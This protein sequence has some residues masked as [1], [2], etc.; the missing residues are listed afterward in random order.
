VNRALSLLY[1]WVLP[2]VGGL[3]Y[4][5]AL[6]PYNHSE[7]GW[8]ALVPLLFALE[9][10]RPGEAFRRGFLAGLVFFGMTTWWI[11][12]VSLPGMVA[13]IAFL[14]LYFGLAGIFLA[15]LSNEK[16]SVWRNIFAAVISA[17]GWVT[18]EW[19]RG[20]FPL[21]GF[22]WNGLGVTQFTATPLIQ[23]ANVTGVYGVSA[24]VFILNYAFFCTIRRYLRNIGNATPVRRLSW[25]FYLAMLL[26][27]GAF[28]TGL[29]A[30]DALPSGNSRL[31]RLALVQGNIPQSLKFDEHEKPMILDRYRSLTTTATLEQVDLI[32][33]PETAIPEALRYDPETFALVTNITAK[34]L[35]HLLTGTIDFTPHATPE[36]AFNAA[37][38]VRP[39]GIIAGIYRKIHLVPFGEYIPLRKI[40]PVFKW[41]TPITD[42]FECGRD[43]TLFTLNLN[44]PS[45]LV[46]LSEAKGLATAADSEVLRSAQNDNEGKRFRFGTVICFEDT[47]PDLYRQFVKR[48][49]EFMVNLTNDA[50]FQDSPAAEMH[51][52]NAIFRTVET[53]RSLVRCTNNGVTCLVDQFGIVRHQAAPFTPATL[54]FTLPVSTKLPVTF[55][56]R[57][58][59][60][61]TGGCALLAVASFCLSRITR[62]ASPANSSAC[63]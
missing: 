8:V 1:R 48:G 21:G 35:A 47:L 17:A 44:Q 45:K 10:C 56:T 14:A 23:F 12:H 11:I 27:G 3:F 38:L 2:V 59:D 20:H 50:W 34:T 4:A 33:W 5:L 28:M 6:P 60:V 49:A 15:Q 31:L 54:E 19:V 43:A 63:R 57:Y 40:L 24:L 53:R 22:G 39:D 18:L 16:D 26:I 41:F 42:S 9:G 29:R 61:F 55:Y 51:L 25:E 13:L 30:I 32:I 37:A 7:L 46:T 62:K 58:G 36:E 52:A